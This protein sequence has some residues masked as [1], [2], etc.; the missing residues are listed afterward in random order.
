M[1]R[2]AR[3]A[4]D[5][6]DVLSNR[7]FQLLLLASVSSPM[8]ASVVSPA[9]EALIGPY[10]ATEASIGLL[11]SAFTAPA[12]VAIPLS[13]VLS[14]RF[15]RKP[16]LTAGL[17]VFGLAGLAIPLTTDF[18]VALVL[19]AIQGVGYTG[20]A[21]VL[22]T[23]VG[24]LFDG[25]REA[26]AQGLRF[27]TVGLSLAVF[28]LIA[29]A[30]VSFGWQLPFL[31][32][33]VALPTALA[34]G[35]LFEEPRSAGASDRTAADGGRTATGGLGETVAE[36]WTLVRQPSVAAILVG[37]MAPSFVWFAFLTYNSIIIVRLLGGTAGTAGAVV[38]LT[39]VSSAVGGT[40]VGRL[41]GAFDGRRI[42]LVGTLALTG[43]GVAG[44]AVAPSIPAAAA[45]AVVTG[46]GFGISLSLIRSTISEL[47]TDDTRG[48]LVST[49]ESLGRIGS[50][51]AP[52]VLGAAIAMGRQTTDFAAAVRGTVL[53]AAVG[54]AAFGIVCV[55]VATRDETA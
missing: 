12:I 46:A 30:T 5:D 33:A 42:P 10:G 27:T 44:F 51:V 19:R 52:L 39:S 26:A 29:G 9:L 47:G 14:D 36:L 38:A 45:A 22:I 54:G 11:M 16:V 49:A 34:V 43:A 4:G 31:L 32:F 15:G 3:L 50:T 55:L 23:S 13:G 48:G 37:R 6:A 28:P 8:G 40:Q 35:W 21:P 24:D 25:D 18:R 1:N 41:V 7:N 2:L 53:V 17:V 20:I